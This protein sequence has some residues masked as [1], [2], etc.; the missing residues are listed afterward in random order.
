LIISDITLAIPQVIF[1]PSLDEI[2]STINRVS[3]QIL[4]S[5]KNV[6]LW[7]H[8]ELLKQHLEIEQEAARKRGEDKVK[9]IQEAKPFDKQLRDHKDVIKSLIP[10]NT[11]VSSLKSDSESL[12]KSFG[13]YRELWEI[14][15]AEKVRRFED[16]RQAILRR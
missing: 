15:P 7:N 10:L 11:V 8:F 6:A 4:S 14:D 12:L 3:D 1:N 16:E 9:L 2:Q 13:D 5:G